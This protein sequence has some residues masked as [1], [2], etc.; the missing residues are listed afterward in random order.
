MKKTIAVLLSMVMLMGLGTMALAT[1]ADSTSLPEKSLYEFSFNVPDNIIP[2]E[3]TIV[4][5]TL[6]TKTLGAGGYDNVR[7]EII[8]AVAPGS[9]TVTFKATD[10]A[11]R[12]ISFTNNGIF[13]PSEHYALPAQY[14]ETTDWTMNFSKSG[15]YVINFKAYDGD[16]Y[17]IAQGSQQITVAD[18]SFTCTFPKDIVAGEEITANVSFVT[19]QN[20]NSVHFEFQKTAGTGD[21]QFRAQDS[22]GFWYTFNNS[23]TWGSRFDITAPYNV[24]TPWKLTFSKAGFYTI[25]FKLV[26]QDGKVLIADRQDVTVKEPAL[27][28]EED[29]DEDQN[30]GNINC[31]GNTNGLMNALRN[32]LKAKKNGKAKAR[33]RS[34][35]RLMELLQQR[36]VSAEELKELVKAME[37]EIAANDGTDEDY[38]ALSR[39]C[40]LKGERHKTYVNGRKVKYDV[41]PVVVKGRTLVP[42]RK[43]AEELGADVKWVDAEK[44][45][46]VTKGKT[47]IILVLGQT[48][49]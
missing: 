43:I 17:K 9:G 5:V 23:G 29:E 31:N 8:N 34:T 19:D 37:K 22:N 24:T 25:D 14:N 36:G 20:Y 27:D 16:H 38:R 26:D 46:I 49:P 11:N 45:V 4:P 39:M 2:G 47:T 6:K 13:I 44:K 32:H 28:E 18:G 48:P 33:A 12:T 42:F 10:T 7:F 41:E 21:V 40:K 1:N 30:D 3:D 35:A 15:T